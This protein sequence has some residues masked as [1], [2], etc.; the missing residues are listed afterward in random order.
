MP[1]RFLISNLPLVTHLK[2]KNM[3]TPITR[4][5]TYDG[6]TFETQEGAAA[7]EFQTRMKDVLKGLLPADSR[8]EVIS[9]LLDEHG[10]V[11]VAVTEYHQAMSMPAPMEN[12]THG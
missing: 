10:A 5:E 4:Y 1:G 8:D 9:R 2:E 12:P 3:S 6:K 7:H 11:H